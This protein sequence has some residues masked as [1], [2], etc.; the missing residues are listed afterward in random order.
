VV[1]RV[2]TSLLLH[3]R[4][5]LVT[6]APPGEHSGTGG[7]RSALSAMAARSASSEDEHVDAGE[8]LKGSPVGG[9][10]STSRIRRRGGVRVGSGG[11]RGGERSRMSRQTEPG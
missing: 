7:G 1:L 10:R 4:V 5:E 11:V 2:P 9:D 8:R 6:D 3:H